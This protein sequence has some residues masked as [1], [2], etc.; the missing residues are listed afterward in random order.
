MQLK[1]HRSNIKLDLRVC[2]VSNINSSPDVFTQI[3]Y[4]ADLEGPPLTSALNHHSFSIS[5]LGV[6]TALR[7]ALALIPETLAPDGLS[8]LKKE[9]R[10][11]SAVCVTLT[12]L[13]F[14]LA[15]PHIRKRT[16]YLSVLIACSS[17]PVFLPLMVM[18]M[19]AM[20]ATIAY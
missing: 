11:F 9:Y 1:T 18:M 2:G 4:L 7:V 6:E 15:A 17:V 10:S 14:L 12:D 3:T 8:F 16:Q 13:G 20:L 5:Q 19:M